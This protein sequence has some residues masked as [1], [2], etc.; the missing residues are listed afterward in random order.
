MNNTFQIEAGKKPPRPRELDDTSTPPALRSQ[1]LTA[2][3]AVLNSLP[4][5]TWSEAEKAA[6]REQVNAV[7][8]EAGYRV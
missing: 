5:S 6:V 7:L 8:S 2:Y 1:I 3:T 4:V